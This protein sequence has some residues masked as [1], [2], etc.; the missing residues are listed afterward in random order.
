MIIL[1]VQ[2]DQLMAMN[3]NLALHTH[4]LSLCL[5]SPP[6]TRNAEELAFGHI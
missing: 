1:I 3:H 5:S 2:H 4:T 6:S